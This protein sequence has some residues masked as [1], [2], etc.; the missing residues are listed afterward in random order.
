MHVFN[1]QGSMNS[2][3]W[4]IAG[5][6]DS[7]LGRSSMRMP[8]RDVEKRKRLEIL[9]GCQITIFSANA[10]ALFATTPPRSQFPL[11]SI[12]NTP[13]LPLST[14]GIYMALV[15]RKTSTEMQPGESRQ[16]HGWRPHEA[17][18]SGYYCCNSY[19]SQ[20]CR[21]KFVSSAS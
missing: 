20:A 17:G 11:P 4:R 21:G 7:Q 1:P 13:L 6:A 5:E 18:L 19:S 12:S 8:Q 9:I 16:A 2:T 14:S 3:E 10:V 15:F